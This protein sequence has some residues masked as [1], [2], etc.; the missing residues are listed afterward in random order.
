[1]INAEKEIERPHYLVRDCFLEGLKQIWEHLIFTKTNPKE[2][3]TRFGLLE[4]TLKEKYKI[5]L[6]IFYVIDRYEKE[7]KASLYID[8][9][10]FENVSIIYDN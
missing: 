1:M 2:I 8:E 6:N 3:M 5:H 7:L 9:I 4:Q 10:L